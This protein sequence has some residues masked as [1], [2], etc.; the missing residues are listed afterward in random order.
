ML[1]RHVIAKFIIHFDLIAT[2]RLRLH[3][4]NYLNNEKDCYQ[5]TSRISKAITILAFYC[6]LK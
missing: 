5:I 1:F 3:R 4:K 2:P 6:P